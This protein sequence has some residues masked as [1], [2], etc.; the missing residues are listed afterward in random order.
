MLFTSLKIIHDLELEG[1][2][3]KQ[4]CLDQRITLELAFRF[5]FGFLK[6]VLQFE[7]D[8]LISVILKRDCLLF[9]KDKFYKR[10]SFL[11]H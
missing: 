8:L 10:R 7:I 5:K 4:F 1:S 2:V 3:K 6:C 11:R 9:L